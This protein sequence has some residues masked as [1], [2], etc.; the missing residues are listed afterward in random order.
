MGRGRAELENAAE[1]GMGGEQRRGDGGESDDQT[2]SLCL[3][4]GLR[5][6]PPDI[7]S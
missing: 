2:K 6:G 7:P 4:G 5:V 3:D 1:V